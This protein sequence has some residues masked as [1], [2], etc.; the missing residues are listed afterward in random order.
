M[1]EVITIFRLDRP[2]PADDL[3]NP[4]DR[5]QAVQEMKSWMEWP[6]ELELDGY[7]YLYG[8]EAKDWLKKFLEGAYD[9]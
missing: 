7:Q 5:D 8:S 4:L 3:S 2:K 1:T 6:Y 9:A